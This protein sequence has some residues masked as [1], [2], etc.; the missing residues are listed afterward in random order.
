MSNY[1]VISGDN[2]IYEPSDLWVERAEPKF[3]DRLPHIVPAEP[4]SVDLN[5][6]PNKDWWVCEGQTLMQFGGDPKT[7]GQIRGP[8]GTPCSPQE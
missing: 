4:G 8:R 1:R 6:R 5:G 3:K 2:H 7:W